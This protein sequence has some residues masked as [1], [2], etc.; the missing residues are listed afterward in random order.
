MGGG[1][2]KGWIVTWDLLRNST[3]VHGETVVYRSKAIRS[4][5]LFWLVVGGQEIIGQFQLFLV[6]VALAQSRRSA[7]L[8]VCRLFI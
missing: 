6:K 7:E 3:A 4:S 8:L 2:N 5:T 1:V